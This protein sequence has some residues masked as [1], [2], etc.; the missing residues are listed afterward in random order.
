MKTVGLAVVAIVAV[1]THAIAGDGALLAQACAGCHG[2][3]GAGQGDV[4]PIAGYDR[5]AFAKIWSEFRANERA[6][7]IMN[8][9]ARGYGDDEVAELAA[10]FAE[11]K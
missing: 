11:L 4:P 8:R 6:A 9:I 10:Y 1:A 5:E 2:Q 3:A 7:T